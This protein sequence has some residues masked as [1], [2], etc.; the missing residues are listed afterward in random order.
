ML[1]KT[2]NTRRIHHVTALFLYLAISIFIFRGPLL[3]NDPSYFSLAGDLAVP[4]S[5][6]NLIQDYYPTWSDQFSKSNLMMITRYPVILPFLFLGKILNLHPMLTIEIFWL[7]TGTLAGLSS[8]LLLYYL[9]EKDYPENNNLKFI[10]SLIS[11]FFFLF[12]PYFALKSRHML[13]RFIHAMTPLAFLSFLKTFENKNIKNTFIAATV[14]LLYSATAR[15]VVYGMLIITLCALYAVIKFKLSI[16][17]VIKSY[18]IIIILFFLL[19]S[20]YIFPYLYSLKECGYIGP[21]YLISEHYLFMR[22]KLLTP[23]NILFFRMFNPFIPKQPYAYYPPP[24]FIKNISY[25]LPLFSLILI[26]VAFSS[27]LKRKITPMYF[28][29]QAIASIMII[30]VSHN[31]LRELYVWVVLYS[32]LSS[33][34]AWV[35]KSPYEFFT[36]YMLSISVLLGFSLYY[37]LRFLN[38]YLNKKAKFLLI[39]SVLSLII[40]SSSLVS[41]PLLTGDFNGELAPVRIPDEYFVI[42]EW[43]GEQEQDFKVLWIPKYHVF[44]TTWRSRRLTKWIDD[45]S[46]SKPTFFVSA[47]GARRTENAFFFEFICSIHYRWND[48]ILLAKRTN[49]L[50]NILSPLGIKYVLF[51][52]DVP[53]L[54]R[55]NATALNT[56][57]SQEDLRYVNNYG[58]IYVFEN[59]RPCFII[60]VPSYIISAQNSG[61]DKIV[62]FADV[63]ELKKTG[64]IFVDKEF[65]P[66]YLEMSDFIVLGD[67]RYFIP[68]AEDFI[69]IAPFNQIKKHNPAKVWSIARTWNPDGTWW[70]KFLVNKWKISNWDFDYGVGIVYTW[71]K[72]TKSEIKFNLDKTGNYTLFIRYFKNREGGA[73]RVYIDDQLIE[74]QTTDQLNKFIF[75][76]I[77]S[78]Y[79][80]KGKHEIVLENVKGFNA[81]NFFLLVPE[82]EYY[83]TQQE[84]KNLL[85]NKTIIY[86]FE[87]ETDLY[88]TKPI[89]V[90]NIGKNINASNGQLV[91]L[92]GWNNAWQDIQVVKNGTYRIALKGIGSFKVKIGGYKFIL[93]ST[94]LDF[95]Y[96]PPFS[97][98]EG[99]YRLE[100]NHI[101]RVGLDTVWFYSTDEN[102]TIDQLFGS[103]EK[104]AQIISYEKINPTLWKVVVNA[105]SPFMLSFAESYD[106]LWRANVYVDNKLVETVKP[107]PLYS[108]INGFWINQTGIIKIVIRYTPQVWFE[109]GL[110]VSAT[111]LFG[112]IMCSV[113]EWMSDKHQSWIVKL[114]RL[115]TM[116]Y[117]KSCQ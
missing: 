112:C 29:L 11:G 42:N 13:I 117:K 54:T 30:T 77:G 36:F 106:P 88:Y 92:A 76:E 10:V 56:L 97:L 50:G 86:L 20:F 58:F 53:S 68:L 35:L 57:L 23:L 4:I 71:A 7:I 94:S 101:G 28:A 51:H 64:V 19:S 87:A 107:V 98:S 37:M 116:F 111:T 21:S 5:L 52:D 45:L 60:N 40:L 93:N 2:L 113:Y 84:V 27:I 65:R 38:N 110:A 70:R 12:N 73:I 41:W 62:S 33:K 46:S 47:S 8:Y 102:Q 104:P 15:S 83:V 105:T 49:T 82:Q 66:E 31:P 74:I 72:G 78:F 44:V 67:G 6:H 63:L 91:K 39:P 16:R 96:T 85:Q 26:T 90:K 80:Q 22:T 115:L 103:K 18:V 89:S 25:L 9:I 108:V 32:P 79:L 81:V 24:S 3:Q 114:K 48:D 14:L 109:Y 69:L 34:F 59:E 99:E 100:I 1:N 43:L 55:R 75:E 17:R 95:V 61:L